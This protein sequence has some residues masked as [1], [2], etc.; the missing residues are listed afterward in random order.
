MRVTNGF[1]I[2]LQGNPEGFAAAKF[3]IFY[4]WLF[5]NPEVDNIMNIGNEFLH[6]L[7]MYVHTI[8]VLS[9]SCIYITLYLLY[10]LCIRTLV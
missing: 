10:L 1:V 6:Y 7:L 2:P 4:D 5:Y 8:T 3:A 9:S